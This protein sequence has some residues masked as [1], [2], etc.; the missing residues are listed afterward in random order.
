[1]KHLI[2]LGE[3]ARHIACTK[4]GQ[5][6]AHV[7]TILTLNIEQNTLTTTS[8]TTTQHT[9]TSK[10]MLVELAGSERIQ[11]SGATGYTIANAANNN[12]YYYFVVLTYIYII[13]LC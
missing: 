6:T 3:R 12:R 8:N 13:L 5:S 11:K 10:V 9:A 1:M 2:E 4:M 7:H